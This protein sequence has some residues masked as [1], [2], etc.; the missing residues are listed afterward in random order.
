MVFQINIKNIVFLIHSF[1]IFSHDQ[2][3]CVK[4]K[5][6]LVCAVIEFIG[7]VINHGMLKQGKN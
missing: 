6:K 7:Y 2:V 1:Q 3:V 4:Q 5:S